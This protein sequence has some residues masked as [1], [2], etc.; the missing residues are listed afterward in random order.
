[1]GIITT[2]SLLKDSLL[3]V[4]KLKYE[5]EI[6]SMYRTVRAMTS[7]TGPFNNVETKLFSLSRHSDEERRPGYSDIP[8]GSEEN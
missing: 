5:K 3:F 2:V 1:M 6:L 8:Y 4:A 7:G